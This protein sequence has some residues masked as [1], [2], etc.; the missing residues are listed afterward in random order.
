M[1]AIRDAVI[2]AASEDSM[3]LMVAGILNAE[4]IRRGGKGVGD[5][6]RA[7]KGGGG[8]PN[9]FSIEYINRLSGGSEFEGGWGEGGGVGVSDKEEAEWRLENRVLGRGDSNGE[10]T[11][12]KSKLSSYNPYGQCL[13]PP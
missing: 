2:W 6:K 7:V 4:W 1:E 11:T 13:V 12:G 9:R 10:G 8:G 5:H 3:L